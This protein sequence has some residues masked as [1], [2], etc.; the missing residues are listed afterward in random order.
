MKLNLL[1]ILL[2]LISISYYAT[3][4]FA[5]D[6]SRVSTKVADDRHVNQKELIELPTNP[7]KMLAGLVIDLY[8]FFFSHQDNQE[9]QFDPSCS[10]FAKQ[11]FEQYDPLQAILMTSDRLIRCNPFAYRYYPLNSRGSLRDPVEEN[12]IW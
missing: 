10:E 5:A 7:V 8:Q 1:I 6:S 11:A 2:S 12:T 3:G 4:L 9:C